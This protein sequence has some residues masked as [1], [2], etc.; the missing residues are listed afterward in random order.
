[1]IRKLCLVGLPLLF[2]DFKLLQ[3][4]IVALCTIAFSVLQSETRPYKMS[5]DNTLRVCTEQHTVIL[6][7]VAGALLGG[8]DS[9]QRRRVR[10]NKSTKNA[11]SD[12]WL[13]LDTE[14]AMYDLILVSSFAVMVVA[15]LVI[16]LL[17][18]VVSVQHAM[19]TELILS[20]ES[21][22]QF[23]RLTKVFLRLV[24]FLEAIGVFGDEHL[25]WDRNE[26]GQ[27]S[28]AGTGVRMAYAR[29]QHGLCGVVDKH[30]LQTYL[31][32]PDATGHDSPL[33]ITQLQNLLVAHYSRSDMYSV[34]EREEYIEIVHALHD[35]RVQLVELCQ[36]EGL[37][38]TT[39]Y[40]APAPNTTQIDRRSR[41]VE[42]PS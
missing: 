42:R 31:S 26:G 24:P 33:V 37:D 27:Q 28:G 32:V 2:R 23:E 40:A 15:P 36:S 5:L 38:N 8:D 41:A 6:A 10:A 39:I 7:A 35:D 19:H 4:V 16:T 3:A 18:K 29:F 9:A 25:Q 34:E 13:G 20:N 17:G 21:V 1:M 12:N 11:G 14:D 30:R 22:Q